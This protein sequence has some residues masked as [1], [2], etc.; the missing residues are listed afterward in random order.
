MLKQSL[1]SRFNH[2]AEGD[3]LSNRQQVSMVYKLINHSG[4]G[5]TR[6]EFVNHEPQ[7]SGLLILPVRFFRGFTGT[8]THS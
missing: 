4:F 7:A 1:S 2:L 8:I 6:E 3:Y 5:R